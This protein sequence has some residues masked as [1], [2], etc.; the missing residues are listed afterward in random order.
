MNLVLQPVTVATGE[1]GEGRLVLLEGRLVAVLV[2]LSDLHGEQA[3]WWFVEKGFGPLD[4]PLH[5][6]FPDLAQAE[7]WL[8]SEL[9]DHPRWRG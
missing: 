2:R 4:R 9:A 3:G 6:S 7:A 8:K 1:A 5:P